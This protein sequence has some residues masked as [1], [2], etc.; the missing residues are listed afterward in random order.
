MKSDRKNPDPT[1]EVDLLPMETLTQA[2]ECLKVMAH[3]VRLRIVDLLMQGEFIVQEIAGHCGVQPHQAC[4]HLR[5]MKGCGLLASER[6]GR[7]VYYRILSPQLPGL[8]A[9]VRAHCG[10]GPG[11]KV[12]EAGNPDPCPAGD[13]H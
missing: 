11:G 4:E 3:P 13:Q 8:L 1:A 9:C 10:K 7:E 12:D 5:L 2:A 6:R